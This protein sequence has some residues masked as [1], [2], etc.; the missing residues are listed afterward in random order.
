MEL[1][2]HEHQKQLLERVLEC[3]A[4]LK[5]TLLRLEADPQLAKSDR[6]GAIENSLEA[7][8]THLANGWDSIDE[9]ESDEISLWLE[10]SE[11]LYD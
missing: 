9:L 10:S 11:Y 6:A 8:E 3:A 7:L 1:T 2:M 5:A 4:R